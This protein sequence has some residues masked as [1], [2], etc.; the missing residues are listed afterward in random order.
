MLKLRIITAV[1]LIPIVIAVL[2]YLSPR[3][4]F[5]FTLFISL[6]A[7]WEWSGLMDVKTTLRRF[8][9]LILVA[10]VFY[11]M[12]FVHVLYIFLF[13]FVW[14]LF[15]ALLIILYPKG[16]GWWSKGVVVRGIMG[17]CVLTP[18]WVAFNFIRNA[19]DGE[20]IY[21][22]LFLFILIWGADSAAYFVGKKWGK[23]KLAPYVSPGKS[24]EG[25]YGAIAISLL[26]TLIA[27]WVCRIP[28]SV[29]PWAILLSLLTVLFSVVG[30]LFESMLKRQAN[31]KDSSQLL[32]GHGG[33][34]DRIDS[35][36]AA[37]PLF[38]LGAML[39][40]MYLD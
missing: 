12:V 2:F 9:Y 18:C 34:L 28:Q 35:L 40:G 24:W 22:L 25:L 5:A 37:A 19:N 4:F 26:I 27:L 1:I 20:G 31:L 29:W 33:L 39:L 15:A 14:W 13:T 6:I 16:A 3:S 17:I 8:I 30:D 7:A 38:A 21:A 23:N 36:T 10:C 32:P 11:S